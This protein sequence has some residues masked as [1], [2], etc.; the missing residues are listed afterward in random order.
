MTEITYCLE[1]VI[2]K[3]DDGT[4]LCPLLETGGSCEECMEIL[5]RRADRGDD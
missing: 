5:E 1:A 4:I 2:E 3:H